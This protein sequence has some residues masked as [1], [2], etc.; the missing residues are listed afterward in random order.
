MASD[1]TRLQNL[2]NHG[3][4]DFAPVWSPDGRYVAFD[5]ILSIDEIDA[6]EFEVKT[7]VVIVDVF[8]KRAYIV[9][10][11]ANVVGWMLQSP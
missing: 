3:A 9:A 7:Q 6:R 4:D 5:N 1:G 10:Q 8:E 2:T 11:D